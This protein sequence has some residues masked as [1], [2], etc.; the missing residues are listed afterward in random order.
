MSAS[1][2]VFSRRAKTRIKANA[3][4]TPSNSPAAGSLRIKCGAETLQHEQVS[5]VALR[6]GRP[7]N[8]IFVSAEAST[9]TEE[10]GEPVAE[11]LA[12]SACP[13]TASPSAQHHPMENHTGTLPFRTQAL[14]PLPPR[15][16]S[17]SLWCHAAPQQTPSQ[18]TFYTRTKTHLRDF[19]F[20]PPSIPRLNQ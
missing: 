9:S 7:K 3:M 6:S 13:A 8:R 14:V 17:T 10:P 18:G 4:K 15:L 1:H 11:P 16:C 19:S 20:R 5:Y 12:A 2:R